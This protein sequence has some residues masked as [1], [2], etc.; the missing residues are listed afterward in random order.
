MPMEVWLGGTKYH[1]K[2]YPAMR[3]AMVNGHKDRGVN[4]VSPLVK[5]ALEA[6]GS[7]VKI[8]PF[9][10]GHQLADVVTQIK[11]MTWLI[12]GSK[13]YEGFT[14]D[15]E[16]LFDTHFIEGEQLIVS[17]KMAFEAADR[18]FTQVDFSRLSRKEVLA[19]LGDPEKLNSFSE[20]KGTEADSPLIYLLHDGQN[21][22]SWELI[23]EDDK[24][25]ELRSNK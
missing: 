22:E 7:T 11:A 14:K 16:L 19:M 12:E 4:R 24:V 18:I 8:F 9:E 5:K 3:V 10:G 20:T 23:F 15:K 1:D 25:V 2:P 6:R 21:Q 13:L 17:S